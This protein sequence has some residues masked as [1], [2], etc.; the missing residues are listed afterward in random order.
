M[1]DAQLEKIEGWIVELEARQRTLGASRTSYLR[2]FVASLVASALGFVW[3]V[4]IGAAALFTGVLF[5][6]F[7]FYVVLQ[8]EAEYRRELAQFRETARK[9]REG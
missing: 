9:L 4:W 2:F 6:A 5:C 3:N 7:G 1:S 8:R